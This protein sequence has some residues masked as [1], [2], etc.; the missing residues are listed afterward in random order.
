MDELF[1]LK[2]A[3]RILGCSEAMLRKWIQ[4]RKLPTVKVGRLTRIRRS[5]LEAW[6]RLGLHATRKEVKHAS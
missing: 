2:E 5:D 4:H 3:A 1:S 6:M